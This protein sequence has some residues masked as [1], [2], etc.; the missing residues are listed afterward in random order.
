M[1]RR[2][3]YLGGLSLILSVL[4][5]YA[6]LFALEPVTYSYKSISLRLMPMMLLLAAAFLLDRWLLTH[7]VNLNL[8]LGL[9]ILFMAAAA[10]MFFYVLHM[11]PVKPGK[12]LFFCIFYAILFP[13]AAYIAYFPVRMPVILGCF[14]VMA[15]LLIVS[16]AISRQEPTSLLLQ[17]TELCLISMLLSL[18][19]LI[20]MRTEQIAEHGGLIGSS[21]AGKVSMLIFLLIL[22]ALALFFALIS[23][24]GSYLAGKT[25]KNAILGGLGGIGGLTSF[26]YQKSEAFFIWLFGFLHVEMPQTVAESADSAVAATVSATE[27]G[28][29]ELPF[30]IRPLGV[31][32]L[33]FGLAVF[34]FRIRHIRFERIEEGE[35]KRKKSV[36]KS[37]SSGAYYKGL[38]A[39]LLSG[40]HFRIE[41]RKKKNTPEG[42]YLLIERAYRKSD[43]RQMAQSGPE[44]LRMLAEKEEDREKAEDFLQLA[45]LLEKSLYDRREK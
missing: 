43:P 11:D 30:W 41:C 5:V 9:Q 36:R 22:A 4:S 10:R 29:L 39:Q 21:L 16:L 45:N 12:V 42:R 6:L 34:L 40:I 7:R 18:V 23:K 37:G 32:L 31:G 13:V 15:F 2:S 3:D 44:Y 1:N 25:A 14:D 35:E 28:R 38:L 26:L 27:S 19:T 33:L 8:F 24:N 20:R 17:T